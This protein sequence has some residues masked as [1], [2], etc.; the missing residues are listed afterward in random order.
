MAMLSEGQFGTG[1]CLS[2]GDC[3][4]AMQLDDKGRLE[5]LQVI[6]CLLRPV[7]PAGSVFAE[8]NTEVKGR[9]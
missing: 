3:R 5:V 8:V 9:G 4:K 7:T 6:V 2:P 1:A